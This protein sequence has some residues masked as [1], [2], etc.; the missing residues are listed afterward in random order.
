M[1]CQS[2]LKRA[3]KSS[4]LKMMLLIAPL[5]FAATAEARKDRPEPGHCCDA[6]EGE[7]L[8]SC[9]VT[10]Y[11]HNVQVQNVEGYSTSIAQNYKALNE[12]GFYGRDEQIAGLERANLKKFRLENLS[13]AQYGDTLVVS[14]DFIAKSTGLTSGPSIDVWHK[15]PKCK[16]W[17]L[18]THFYVPFVD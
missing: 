2:I 15:M 7:K 5:T 18:V 14:Y 9:L 10:E 1:S 6:F 3:F 11:W 4:S 17:K 13:T 12:S 16:M 8:G